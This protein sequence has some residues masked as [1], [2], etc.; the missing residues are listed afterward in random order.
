[1][2][3]TIQLHTGARSPAAISE[4]IVPGVKLRATKADPM[5]DRAVRPPPPLPLTGE[6]AELAARLQPIFA[7]PPR[8]TG[9]AYPEALP[10]DD[11]VFAE[12][13]AAVLRDDPDEGGCDPYQFAELANENEDGTAGAG[14]LP[15]AAPW[16]KQAKR[17]RLRSIARNSLPWLLTFVVIA[18]TIAGTFVALVGSQKSTELLGR[19][20]NRV[21]AGLA[22]LHR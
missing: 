15:A 18:A 6:E 21:E 16:I 10:I 17:A 8:R 13:L 4:P 22:L 5:P 3:G 19:A 11:G 2:V 20:A 7:Q 1:M 9:V 12:R 14:Q